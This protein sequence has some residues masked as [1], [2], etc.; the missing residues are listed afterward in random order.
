MRKPSVSFAKRLRIRFEY[1]AVLSLLR[2]LGFLPRPLALGLSQALTRVLCPLFRKLQW[3]ARRNFELAMPLLGEKEVRAL[4][5]GVFRNLGRLLG[6]FSQLPKLRVETISQVVV[7]DGFENYLESVRRG[8]GTL[9]LTAHFGSWELCPFAHALYGHP[10]KFVIR[11]IDNPLV[12]RLVTRYRTLSGNQII[13]KKD[14][15]KVILRAL[16]ANES[17]GILIDQNTTMDAGVFADFFGVPACTTSSLATIALRTS[18]TVVPGVLIWDEK[19]R[20]HRLHFEPPVELVRSGDLKADIVVNTARFN[21]VLEELV[22]QYPDQW[23]W[24]HRRWKTR[25]P[26]EQPL[27]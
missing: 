27:Y 8:K 19:L 24:V 9:F 21:R 25:P 15:L 12:D 23:L 6:E 22:R 7:Y 5:R 26:N 17:V 2:L 4:T 11:P 10:L 20:K 18:A 13:E 1:A 14:S 3:T 16:K